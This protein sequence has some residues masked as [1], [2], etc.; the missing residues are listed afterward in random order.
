MGL[1]HSDNEESRQ[2]LAAAL[3]DLQEAFGSYMV[4]LRWVSTRAI[5]EVPDRQSSELGL[6]GVTSGNH[7]QA[8]SET[9]HDRSNDA[10]Y[11]NRPRGEAIGRDG[12]VGSTTS[13]SSQP[14]PDRSQHGWI[15]RLLVRLRRFFVA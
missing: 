1:L 9:S 6:M 3:S 10:E 14:S 5:A 2:A 7:T 4:K 12:G 8:R 15:R 13:P 11:L